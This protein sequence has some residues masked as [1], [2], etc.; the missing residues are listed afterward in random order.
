MRRSILRRAAALLLLAACHGA[1]AQAWPSRPIHLVTAFGAGSASDIV[2]RMI[3]EDLRAAFGQ[4]VLVDNKPGASGIIAAEA[5]A[6][7]PPDGYTLFLTTNTVHSGNPHLFKKLPY[8]PIKDFTA[9]ARVC[10]FPFVLEVNGAL[11][12]K[13]VAELASY[14][15][16]NPGKVSYG[17]GNSTGQVASAAFNSLMKLDAA[18]VP[19]K[20]SP[21]VLTDLIG[22]QISFTF[23]DLASSQAQLKAG[24]IRALAVST[25][26]R[27][28]LAPELPTVAAA[29]GLK[30]FDLA[31]W[32][33]VLAPAGLS[34]DIRARLSA[35]IGAMLARKDVV[36]KFTAMGAE[37][38][39]ADGA[40]FDAYMKQQLAVWGRKVQDAGIQPE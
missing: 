37:V 14:A 40:A 4:P 28:A 1:M 27:S 32:V 35:Q 21:Q 20:S 12:V 19:Y 25:E 3:A 17:Y 15:R 6:K 7:S 29:A 2:A 36:D 16:A 11:P 9:I 8:D 39:P 33:G 26:Q 13:S 31:A 10:Y 30:G 23:G 5:V 18:A 38:A 24:R 22:G 34:E